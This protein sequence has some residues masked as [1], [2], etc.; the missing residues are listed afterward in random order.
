MADAPRAPLLPALQTAQSITGLQ[1]QCSVHLSETLPPDH[2]FLELSREALP[3]CGGQGESRVGIWN[4]AG[5]E[6]E[7]NAK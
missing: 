4:F 6:E 7:E 5:K 1:T 3:T 2:I